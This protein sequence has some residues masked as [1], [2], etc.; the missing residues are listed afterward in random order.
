M[1]FVRPAEGLSEARGR[2]VCGIDLTAVCIFKQPTLRV[3]QP[4]TKASGVNTFFAT[5]PSLS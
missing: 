1:H 2:C 4:R 5:F 3:S